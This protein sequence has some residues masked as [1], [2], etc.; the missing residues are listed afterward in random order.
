MSELAGILAFVVLFILFCALP[1]RRK[2]A[3]CGACGSKSEEDAAHCSGCPHEAGTAAAT[4]G[5]PR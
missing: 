3:G 2:G 1:P 5:P 4:E